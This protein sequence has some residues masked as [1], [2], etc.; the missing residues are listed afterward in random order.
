MPNNRTRH[1]VRLAPVCLESAAAWFHQH[2]LALELLTLT[3]IVGVFTLEAL[4]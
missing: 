1:L 3:L 2:P 4:R